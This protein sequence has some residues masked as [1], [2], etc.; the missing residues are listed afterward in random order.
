MN[1][2]RASDFKSFRQRADTLK[3]GKPN[4]TENIISMCI[5]HLQEDNN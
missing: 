3:G 5:E 1:K 4:E 2:Q